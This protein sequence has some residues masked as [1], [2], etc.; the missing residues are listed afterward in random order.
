MG[1]LFSR[2]FKE[3][4]AP[5]ARVRV[6]LVGAGEV[7]FRIAKRLAQDGKEVVVVDL[8][9]ERLSEIQDAMDVQT[10]TGSGSSPSV[11]QEAGVEGAGYFLAVTDRDEINLVSCMFANA[12]AP[13]AVK[14]AR[15]RNPEYAR[16][17][18]LLGSDGLNIRMMV[19]PDE[20]VVRTIDRLLSLPGALDYA[21]FADGRIRMV[22]YKVEQ[23]PF[24]DRPLMRFRELVGDDGIMVA[25]ILR[26]D[27]LIIPDGG[28]AIHSGD[29]VYFVYRAEAQ[30]S[31][32]RALGRTRGFFNTA[33]IIGGGNIGMLLARLFEDKG[34]DV[35]LIERDATRCEELADILDGTLVLHGDGT[36][37]ALLEEENV[38]KMDVVAAVTGD[39][40]TNIL[41]CLLAKSLGVRDTVASVNKAAYLSLME[42]IG[43]DH[44]VSARVAAVNGFLNYIR[45]GRVVASASVGGEAAEVLEAQLPE[46]SP[47]LGKPVRAL[48]LP[49]N[50]LLLAVLRSSE[51]KT[52]VFIPDGGT[53]LAPLDHVILLGTRPAINKLE[54]LLAAVGPN[55]AAADSGI[56]PSQ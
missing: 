38:G 36:D 30:R 9:P 41:S 19:N 33:C 55:L 46:G 28:E 11:L 50:V 10:V 22:E 2:F 45:R 6:V 7:G 1:T 40:E 15:I 13:A 17:P 4:V 48:E 16:Y 26:K 32:L 27:A 44:S 29:T 54:P 43:I 14:L 47:L 8:D 49:R 12:L 51:P 18:G 34:V 25:C 52:G 24:V 20:E 35:K 3:P 21:Q 37:K 42:L 31:L 23:A 53:V 5:A 39:E 56:S